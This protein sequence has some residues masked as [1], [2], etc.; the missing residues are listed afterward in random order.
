MAAIGHGARTEITGQAALDIARDSQP[1]LAPAHDVH[2][3]LG[4]EPGAPVVVMA[5]D[6]GR[7]PIAGELVAANPDRIV[8]ARQA[9]G[10]G[11]L[12]LHFPRVGFVAVPAAKP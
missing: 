7:D 4:L 1:G 12:N 5:D 3:P 11:R 9:E 6:Y 8:I 10:L 2:D